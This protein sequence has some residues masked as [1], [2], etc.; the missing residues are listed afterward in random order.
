MPF[1]YKAWINEEKALLINVGAWLLA[2][3]VG[4]LPI[5]YH[6]GADNKCRFRPSEHSYEKC[7]IRVSP[8]AFLLV[9]VN[10]FLSQDEWYPA[11]GHCVLAYPAPK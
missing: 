5:W 1:K 4:I 10:G 2:T 7:Y 6:K 8:I 3:T 11:L 9:N